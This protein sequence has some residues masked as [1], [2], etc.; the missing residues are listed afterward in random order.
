MGGVAG[1]TAFPAAAARGVAS[2][3]IGIDIMPHV[4]YKLHMAAAQQ[5]AE[6]DRWLKGLRDTRARA[7]VLVRIDRFNSGN[8]GDV[9]PVGDGVSEMRID[10]GPPGYRVYYKQR[11]EV[12]ILLWGGDKDSQAADIRKAKTLASELED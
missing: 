2:P 10:Y 12:T 1:A 4:A 11:G 9:G 7:K 3:V 6:F 8:P 5:T